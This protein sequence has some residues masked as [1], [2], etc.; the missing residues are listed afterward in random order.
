MQK[1]HKIFKAADNRISRTGTHVTVTAGSDD[2]FTCAEGR[3][4]RQVSLGKHRG[5]S[6]RK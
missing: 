6:K 1:Q 5:A 4:R 2:L 3:K